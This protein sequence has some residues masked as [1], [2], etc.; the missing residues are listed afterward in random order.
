MKEIERNDAEIN[1]VLNRAAEGF[2]EGSFFPGMSY[3]QGIMDFANWLFGNSDS[4]P[5]RL[6]R[7]KVG[8]F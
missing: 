4:E 5:F 6:M 3:E 1:R 7:G 8:L 2:D